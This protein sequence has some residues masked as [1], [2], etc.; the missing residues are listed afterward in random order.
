MK[1]STCLCC[2][3][4]LRIPSDST[5]RCS[6]C[7][8]VFDVSLLA[9]TEDLPISGEE[10]FDWKHAQKG[11]VLT[12]SHAVAARIAAVFA[13]P[14]LLCQ[15]FLSRSDVSRLSIRALEVFYQLV[16]NDGALLTA[17]KA[18]VNHYL[19]RPHLKNIT[20]SSLWRI[21]AI[22]LACPFWSNKDSALL[23]RLCGLTSNLPNEAQCVGILYGILAM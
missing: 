9:R 22:L 20:G 18:T 23:S 2:G 19:K 1:A 12:T 10:V 5:F 13:R 7:L 3:T 15:S 8:T 6:I 11:K 14:D 21:F 16:K 4:V 17:F